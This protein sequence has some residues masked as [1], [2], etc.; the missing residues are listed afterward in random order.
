MGLVNDK[1]PRPTNVPRESWGGGPEAGPSRT[2]RGRLKMSAERMMRS[3][4]EII[5]IRTM[6]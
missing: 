4:R 2:V 5:M 1:T 6:H 3:A